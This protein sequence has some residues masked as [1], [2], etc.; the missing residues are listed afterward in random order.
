MWAAEK[1][2]HLDVIKLLIEAG[3]DVNTECHSGLT[4]WMYS[5]A[6]KNE[7]ISSALFKMT[8]VVE[9]MLLRQRLLHL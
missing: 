1:N 9:N 5:I 3:A 2:K 8:L 4:P 7:E 6:N